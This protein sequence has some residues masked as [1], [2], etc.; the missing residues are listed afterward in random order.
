MIEAKIIV[1]FSQMLI[2][3]VENTNMNNVI[4]NIKNEIASNMSI[5]R[6]CFLN[7]LIK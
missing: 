1:I 2:F 7:R 5:S 3:S 6:L 4:Q